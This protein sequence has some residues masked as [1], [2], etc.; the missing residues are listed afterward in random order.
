MAQLLELLVAVVAA[1]VPPGSTVAVSRR[2]EPEAK[3]HQD[4]IQ[5]KTVPL[6][7]TTHSSGDAVVEAVAVVVALA[8]EMA[9]IRPSLECLVELEWLVQEVM[10]EGLAS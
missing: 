1:V 8:A 10:A 2:L 6:H 9:A 3:H 4:K 7:S 5:D